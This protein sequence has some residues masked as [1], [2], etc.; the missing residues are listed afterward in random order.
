VITATLASPRISS[1]AGLAFCFGGGAP[2][3]L[4]HALRSL[5]PFPTP[6]LCVPNTVG[7]QPIQIGKVW[8]TVDE[9]VQAFAIVFARPLAIPHLP[10]RIIRVE[11]RTAQRLPAAMRTAFNV[12]AV[13]M[14]FADGRAAIR[15]GPSVLL[16][17]TLSRTLQLT[18]FSPEFLEPRR[19][20]LG[21]PHRVLDILVT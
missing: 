9:E 14:A 1:N 7:E 16:M 18:L 15:Q 3:P 2:R 12:A 4:P 11:V 17:N 21:I 20:P 10:P 8:I 13:A 19:R 6:R 5:F